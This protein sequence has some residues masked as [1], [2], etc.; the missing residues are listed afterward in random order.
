MK[1]ETDVFQALN[2]ENP[3]ANYACINYNE[4]YALEEIADRSIVI[5][6]DAKKRIGW[7]KILAEKS[8]T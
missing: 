6:R 3:L 7:R 2:A 4:E 8:Y 1:T 5:Y